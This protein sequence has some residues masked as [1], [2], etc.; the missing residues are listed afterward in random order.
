MSNLGVLFAVISSYLQNFR[1][2]LTFTWWPAKDTMHSSILLVLPL[3]VRY[4]E[5]G[6]LIIESQAANGLE[7]WAENFEKV[8]AACILTPESAIR[9]RSSVVWRRVDELSCAHRTEVIALPWAYKFGAFVR[10]YKKTRR[11]LRELISRSTY[12]VFGIGYVWGDW[13]ALACLERCG[14]KDPTRSGPTWWT[15]RS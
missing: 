10:Y 4:D 9:S 13:A 7:R 11:L 6:R 3:P 8:T 15:T 12:L 1:R 5:Q 2:V 14:K